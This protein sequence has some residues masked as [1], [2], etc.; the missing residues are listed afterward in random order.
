MNLT[1]LNKTDKVLD[2]LRNLQNSDGAEVRKEIKRRQLV[3]YADGTMF[4]TAK[5]TVEAESRVGQVTIVGA[6]R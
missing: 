3:G 2:S 1:F 4:M 5:A 6:K